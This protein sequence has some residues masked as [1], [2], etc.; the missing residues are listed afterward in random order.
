M[1]GELIL[2]TPIKVNG[3]T[4]KKIPY[5]FDV[6]TVEDIVSLNKGREKAGLSSAVVSQELDQYCQ[7][8]LFKR[9]AMAVNPS[10][11]E[12]DLGRMSAKDGIKAMRLAR[13]FFLDDETPEASEVMEEPTSEE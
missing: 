1:N 6:L 12:N 3:K 7:L 2:T 4:V 13:D 5:D 9:A 8:A 10:V 11:D